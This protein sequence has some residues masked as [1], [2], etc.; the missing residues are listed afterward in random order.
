MLLNKHQFFLL[1]FGLIITPFLISK[2]I[3][4]ATS[5]K[6]IG[7]VVGIG[8][9][10]GMGL[11][12]SSY[13]LVEFSQGKEI[14]SFHG[15]EENLKEGDQVSVRYPKSNP[16]DAKLDTLLTTLESLSY[17]YVLLIFWFVLYIMPDLIPRHA[18]IQIGNKPFIKVIKER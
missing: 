7:K 13:S 9:Y 11:G 5:Q 18:K 12:E 3:W 4:F 17:M 15:G 1:L 16:E 6:A 2:V 8:H 10:T 14:I